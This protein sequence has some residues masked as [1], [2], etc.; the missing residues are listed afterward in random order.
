MSNGEQNLIK[1]LE[2]WRELFGCETSLCS[3]RIWA[4]HCVSRLSTQ[5]VLTTKI[6][7]VCASERFILK[8]QLSAGNCLDAPEG[9]KLIESLG[10]KAGRHLFMDRAYE[11]DKTRALVLKQGL[12]PVVPPKK[13]RKT[14]WVYDMVLYKRRN[15]IERFFYALSVFAVFL[16]A[17]I[18][19]ILSTLRL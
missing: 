15:E 14:P 4:R 3:C 16:L 7:A 18:S 13:N 5:R 1:K 2:I 10:F 8:C 19:W 17:T 6:H 9:R 11:E 12:I